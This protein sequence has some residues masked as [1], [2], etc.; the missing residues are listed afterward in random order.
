MD[1]EVHIPVYELKNM[2]WIWKFKSLFI[3]SNINW[4]L[5]FKALFMN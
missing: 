4:T 2:D 1:F 5:K 3:K